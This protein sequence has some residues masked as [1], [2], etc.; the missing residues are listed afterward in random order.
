MALIQWKEIKAKEMACL[1]WETQI[2]EATSLS[3]TELFVW[4]FCFCFFTQ[5][6][7][8]WK[9]LGTQERKKISIIIGKGKQRWSSKAF[10]CRGEMPF[11]FFF[12]E[13]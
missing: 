8:R 7:V 10:L 6:K 12:L 1:L 2:K 11:F 9:Y 13:Y 3:Y 5:R 4:G